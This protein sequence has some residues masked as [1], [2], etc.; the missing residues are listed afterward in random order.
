[1]V[2][3]LEGDH[4]AQIPANALPESKSK[5]NIKGDRLS[6]ASRRALER[7]RNLMHTKTLKRNA[8]YHDGLSWESD[9]I[10]DRAQRVCNQ[11]TKEAVLTSIR[12]LDMSAFL[13]VYG[14]LL[15]VEAGN[16]IEVDIRQGTIIAKS[17]IVR[18]ETKPIQ[19]NPLIRKMITTANQ[20]LTRRSPQTRE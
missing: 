14:S 3:G 10:L 19:N 2:E 8:G 4:P 13:L 1:V 11:T 9:R 16:R 17:R 20:E 6:K 7:F 15:D 12:E 5:G 18:T